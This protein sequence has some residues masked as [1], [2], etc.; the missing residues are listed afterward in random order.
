MS[1][2]WSLAFERKLTYV[3]EF[4]KKSNMETSWFFNT[5][6]TWFNMIYN[7]TDNSSL[8]MGNCQCQNLII[9]HQ[10]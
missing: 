5:I 1:G 8:K 2:S 9:I 6:H 10:Q 4:V 3:N 7:I